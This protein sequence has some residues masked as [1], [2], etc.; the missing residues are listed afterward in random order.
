MIP[1]LVGVLVC[2][3]AVQGLGVCTGRTTAGGRGVA[4][5]ALREAGAQT[6]EAR[7]RVE[8]DGPRRNRAGKHSL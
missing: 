7:E 6:V 8:R 4:K 1:E 3:P 2:V 5:V